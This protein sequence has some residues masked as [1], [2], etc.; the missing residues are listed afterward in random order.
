MSIRD[1]LFLAAPLALAACT[2]G[3]NVGATNGGTAG[4]TEFCSPAAPGLCDVAGSCAAGWQTCCQAGAKDCACACFSTGGGTGTTAGGTSAGTASAGT[5]GG[6]CPD[7]CTSD[8]QCYACGDLFGCQLGHCVGDGPGGQTSSGSGGSGGGTTGGG[9]TQYPVGDP[10]CTATIDPGCPCQSCCGADV[11]SIE[12]EC[13]TSGGSSGGGSTGGGC[14]QYPAG[15]VHCSATNEPTCPCQSCCGGESCVVEPEC[16]TSGGSSSGG[17]TGGVCPTS[18]VVDTDCCPA[19]GSCTELVGCLSSTC[20]YSDNGNCAT[21]GGA[22]GGTTGGSCSGDGTACDG[23]ASCCSGCCG[24]SGVA[25]PVCLPATD[26]TGGCPALVNCNSFGECQC[27][28][29]TIGACPTNSCAAICCGNGGVADGG[30]A[31][32]TVITV[33][34]GEAFTGDC[35]SCPAGQ[36]CQYSCFGGVSQCVDAPAPCA[37][38]ACGICGMTC[39]CL[40]AAQDGG[41][42]PCPSAGIESCSEDGGLV[43]FECVEGC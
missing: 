12:P 18:C 16:A 36:M 30:P 40:E 14:T 4:S 32:P 43:T 33:D 42:G 41:A 37:S 20:I 38:G 26:C 15:D 9:C 31:Y 1:S 10:H 27:G 6:S 39:A 19:I 22:G 13:A 11:C 23:P 24:T 21:S 8:S 29:G 2:G 28:N 7:P 35:P 3:L 34:G 25:N 17:S 5:S